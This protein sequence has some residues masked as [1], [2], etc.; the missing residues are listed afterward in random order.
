MY[1]TVPE[2]ARRLKVSP[3]TIWRWINSGSL[4]AYRVGPRKI[5]IK[6]VDLQTLIRPARGKKIGAAAEPDDIWAGYD[7]KKVCEVLEK[8][9]GVWADLD[10]ETMIADLYRAREEGR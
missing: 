7:P 6:T 5:R 1:Y 9:A 2:A 10:I 8:T 4:T 3:S